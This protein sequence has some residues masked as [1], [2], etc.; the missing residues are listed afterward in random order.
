M[1]AYG[2]ERTAT[3]LAE[4]ACH[5]PRMRYAPTRR[6]CSLLF[7]AILVACTA[8][9][10]GQP[11][12]I[13]DPQ[14]EVQVAHFN[15]IDYEFD[16]GSTGTYCAHCNK[17]DGNNRFA[18]IE[19]DGSLWVG[20]VDIDSGDFVPM[21]G[22]GR[23]VD[24]NCT[25]P[26]QIGQGPEWLFSK[27]GSELVYNRWTDGKPH[28]VNY[29]GIGFA[30]STEDALIAGM[31]EGTLGMVVPIGTTDPD[32]RRPAATYQKFALPFVEQSMYWQDHAFGPDAVRH[33]IPLHSRGR[34]IT[35]RWVSGTRDVILTAP[36]P[37]PS[38]DVAIRQ[39]YLYRTLAGTLEQLTFDPTDKIWAFMWPAPEYG[40]EYVF[41]TVA[42]GNRIDIY[43][44]LVDSDGMPRW[45]VVESIHGPADAPYIVSPEPFT[46][47]G[48]SWLSFTL[49]ADQDGRN[50]ASPSKIAIAGILPENAVV[51]ELTTMDAPTRARRDP[52]IY[53][54]TNGPYIYYSRYIPIA[55]HAVSEGVFRVDSGLGPPGQ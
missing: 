49:S 52:E 32:D 37:E 21:D 41:F 31:V 48:Q 28:Y 24:K 4:G 45:T 13:V 12:A 5:R 16:W 19:N 2:L 6:A 50:L 55:G 9:A 25:T 40:G 34:G 14:P 33:D 3:G 7:A 26:L 54:T 38:S 8:S 51:R 20:H 44:N 17:A 18:Y 42:D 30:R 43:R 22:H 15:V 23:V 53:I 46:F 36:E 47:N 29:L 1:D 10:A 39:V 35:R 27:Q 11:A